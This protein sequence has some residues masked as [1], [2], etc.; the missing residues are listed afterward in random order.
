MVIV[1]TSIINI[2]S[3]E[4]YLTGGEL[5]IVYGSGE[6]KK[7]IKHDDV[8]KITRK[9]KVLIVVR[10]YNT[11]DGRKVEDF[12]ILKDKNTNVWISG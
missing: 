2:I 5:E 4:E 9:S 3:S 11:L 7:V 12:Y 6:V 1:M 8:W 10:K